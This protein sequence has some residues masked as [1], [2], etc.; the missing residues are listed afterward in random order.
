MAY[1]IRNVPDADLCLDRLHDLL[2]PGGVICFHEYSVADSVVTTAIWNAV[3]LGIIIPGGLLTARHSKI[4]RYLRRSVLDFD[5]ARDFQ[6][7]LRRH[8]FVD[9][10]AETVDGWQRGIVHSFLARRPMQD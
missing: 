4:Y 1:G 6:A 7:R 10:R 9:V 3:T 5:G 2:V 8:G